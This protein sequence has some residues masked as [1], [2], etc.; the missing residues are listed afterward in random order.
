MTQEQRDKITKISKGFAKGFRENF[1]TI[2]GSGPF[3][4]DPLSGFLNSMGYENNL[5]QIPA[6]DGRPQV[7]IIQFSDG[8]I[9]I[10]AG[11]DIGRPDARDWLWTD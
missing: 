4:V 8:D 6:K 9:F 2:A 5:T 3:I 7:L 10:P 1:P 11:S